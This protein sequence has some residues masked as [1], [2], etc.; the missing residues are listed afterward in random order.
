MAK[1]PT[2]YD[3]AR[4]AGV[5]KSLVSL[6]LRGS[7]RVSDE[8][9]AAVLTAVAEL[10]YTPSRL[11]AGLAGSRTR[12]VGVVIDE[13]EN[14]WFA[15]VL[16]GLRASLGGYSLSVADAALNAHLG[17]DP[18]EAFRSL[19]VD[20]LVLAGEVPEAAVQRLGIP[21]VVLGT[22]SMLLPGAPLVAS[23][24]R[25]GGRLATAHLAELGHRDIVCL[26]A[27]GAS[28]AAREAGYRE[29]MGERGLA[30]RVLRAAR[31]TESAAFAA[32]AG[33]FEAARGGAAPPAPS[34]V[35][36][37]ND[38]MAVGVIGA[39]RARGIEVPCG[40]AVVGYDDSPI[41]AYE[42]LSL[43]S[44]SGD[45]RELGEVAGRA[46]RELLADAAGP[47]PAGAS[48][49][50]REPVPAELGR[51]AAPGRAAP[52]PAALL[53]PRLIVRRSSGA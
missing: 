37:V 18:V 31:T 6:V 2:I 19:R 23:D 9:R 21:A 29:E 8:K 47:V 11:A 30:P 38:P 12:S 4:R 51:D 33:L 48:G 52:A 50:A 43:T 10:D 22:R 3:V 5:S 42:T 17:L 35:F 46:L 27:T 14:L 45:P 39:A 44:V 49:G 26:S 41:A 20:G 15:P 25:A 13:F 7:S 40:L 1:A 16:A 53:P 34:A 24:E 32:A 36:A 28:S